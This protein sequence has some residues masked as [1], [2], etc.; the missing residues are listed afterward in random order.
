MAGKISTTRGK[1]EAREEKVCH[2]RAQSPYFSTQGGGSIMQRVETPISRSAAL[3]KLSVALYQELA[4]SALQ[5]LPLGRIK[6]LLQSP[7][8]RSTRQAWV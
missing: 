2:Q 6:T 7:R 3:V 5:L 8:S 1:P 4:F